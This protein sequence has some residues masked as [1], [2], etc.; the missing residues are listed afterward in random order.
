MG[1]YPAHHLFG[2]ATLEAD[3]W[4]VVDMSQ[5]EGGPL[6]RLGRRARGQLGDLNEQLRLWR[7]RDSRG[8]V[9]AAEPDSVRLVL[10]AK[11][12]GLRLPPCIVAVHERPTNPVLRRVL[13]GIDRIVAMSGVVADELVADGVDP[14]R[15]VR[16][17]WGP[18]LTFPGY[19]LPTT[20]EIVLSTGKSRRD[21]ATLLA[22][23]D[24]TDIPARVYVD[25]ATLAAE[26]TRLPNVT[27][28]AV[29][30]P[31]STGAPLSYEH[32]LHDLRRAAVIAVPLRPSRRPNGLTEI[33]DALAFGKPVV[34][35]D[36]PYLPCDVEAVGCGF[37]VAVG[38]V[39]GW[40]GAITR[41]MADEPLRREMGERGRRWAESN[42]NAELFGCG[43]RELVE[44]V[45]GPEWRA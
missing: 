40:R 43:I 13:G 38:D 14:A 34:V 2:T 29:A 30:R 15:I 1:T 9:V 21:V 32:V 4:V 31:R 16:L 12:F 36:T 10:L 20:S 33:C 25:D 3:G 22:A 27:P 26:A 35:T 45:L 8:V 17:P 42:F 39:D 37:R 24:G 6:V 41:L 11:S 28:V 5:D 7:A 23:L 44:S 19:A 18:D